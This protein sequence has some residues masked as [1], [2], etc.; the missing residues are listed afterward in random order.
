[1][2]VVCQIFWFWPSSDIVH[3]P[4]VLVDHEPIQGAAPDPASPWTKDD[5][6]ITPLATYTI[7]ARVLSKERYRY[8]READLSPY[9]LMLGWLEM[10]DERIVSQ[11]SF[12]QGQRWGF[13][14]TDR[15]PPL[16]ED[17]VA[18]FAAN[19]HILPADEAVLKAVKKLREGDVIQASGYLVEV[20][21]ED[22]WR[23]RSSLS[24]TD[25]RGGSCEVFWVE[26]ISRRPR[27]VPVH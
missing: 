3:P 11:F 13:W 8:D 6:R 18:L 21:A 27:P 16:K 14:K 4:G 2:T 1:M 15:T 25:T 22:G 24:R 10:S 5:Y 7:E 20:N 12:S 9:D 23:W 17:E 19:T 26:S